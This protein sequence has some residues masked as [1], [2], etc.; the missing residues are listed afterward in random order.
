M[1]R[2]AEVDNE[3]AKDAAAEADSDNEEDNDAEADKLEASDEA[4]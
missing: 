4:E 1:L 3:E 2:L